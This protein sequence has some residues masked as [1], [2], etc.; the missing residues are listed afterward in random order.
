MTMTKN[1]LLIFG[2]ILIITGTILKIT[3]LIEPWND[4]IFR[5]GLVLG[6]IYFILNM[7]KPGSVD[8]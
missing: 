8:K 3:H 1:T 2:A 7:R 5:A 4:W 6:F